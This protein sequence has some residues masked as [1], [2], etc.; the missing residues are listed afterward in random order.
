MKSINHPWAVSDKYRNRYGD[1][2]ADLDFVFQEKI[3]E[4]N[5]RTDPMN[6]KI[7][8]LNIYNQKIDMLYKDIIA[9]SKTIKTLSDESYITGTKND[10]TF[11]NKCSIGCAYNVA[12]PTGSINW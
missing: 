7:G 3:S 12:A 5:F 11:A 6:T 8:H 9:H 4:E 10:N 1:T 2:W